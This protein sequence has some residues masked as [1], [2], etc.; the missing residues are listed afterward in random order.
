MS[1]KLWIG[2]VLVLV[3]WPAGASDL[4]RPHEAHD[5]RG[6]LL[7]RRSPILDLPSAADM[8]SAV[9][10]RLAT[11]IEVATSERTIVN[12]SPRFVWAS[13]AKAYCG[14]AVGYF[15]GGEVNDLVVTK[16]DCFY[17]RMQLFNQAAR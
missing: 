8:R 14:M 2:L 13:E 5:V 9:D 4:P 6:C 15:D 3:S 10:Q 12:T 1:P 7:A 11:A 16:C 17:E